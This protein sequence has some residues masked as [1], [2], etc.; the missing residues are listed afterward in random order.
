MPPQIP[1][2]TAHGI[3]PKSGFLS[4]SAPLHQFENPYYR[5]WDT[6]IASLPTLIKT[7]QLSH[8]ISNLPLLETEH[9]TTELS[10]R[11]AYVLLAFTIHA[12]VWSASP[13]R[14]KI[15]PQLTEPFLQVCEVL[16][17]QPVITYAG[18][19]LWNWKLINSN[20]ENE[21]HDAGETAMELE[22]LDVLASF[23]G[24][25]GEAAFYLVPVLTEYEGGHL[26]CLLLSVLEKIALQQQQ[27]QPQNEAQRQEEDLDN[28]VITALNETTQALTRMAKHLSKLYALLSPQ[29][30]YH[31]HRPFMA[32]GKGMEDRGL[33]RGMVFVRADGS[34]MESKLA[35]GSAVQS[36]LFPFLDCA[37]GVKHVDSTM[38]AV[39][40]LTLS[41]TPSLPIPYKLIHS[42]NAP[43]HAR[44]PPCLPNPH[45]HSLPNH[46]P[47]HL[48]PL[49]PFQPQSPPRLRQMPLASARLARQTYRAGVAVCCAAC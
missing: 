37:L 32:G 25:R 36:S 23:T 48:H 33:S 14:E 27:Q 30:F 34:E 12:S 18:L 9:L 6:I 42:G 20:P 4:P 24:T 13:P 29:F 39:S 26:V 43:L 47:P 8:A 21:G 31:E 49:P 1:N 22:N 11:R 38:F 41:F 28:L 45:L 5:P 2:P 16:G 46:Q 40:R 44:T 7:N 35:G 19:C 15:P 10:Y 3:S 17:I